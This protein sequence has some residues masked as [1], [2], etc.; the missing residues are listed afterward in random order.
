MYYIV[1]DKGQRR[2]LTLLFH[3]LESQP[4]TPEGRFIILQEIT[5]KL[6]STDQLNLLNLFL[7]TYVEEHKE[8]PYNGYYLLIVAKNYLS[9][10][11]EPFAVQYFERILRNHVDL[12]VDGTSIH[13]VCLQNLIRL[14]E[15]PELKVTYYKSL[16]S[17]FGD[18]TDRGPAY[19]F[20]AKTY[21]EL[22]EW[23][24]AIQAYRNFLG[25]PETSVQGV[26][27]AHEQVRSIIEFYDYPNKNWT[28]ESLEDLVSTIKYAMWTRNARLLSR[29]R[30]K[31]NFF[32]SSWEEEGSDANQSF[33]DDLGS[34]L[35]Q[36]I[37]YNAELDRDSNYREAYLRTWGWSYRIKTWYLYFR[38]VDFPADPEIHGQWEWGGI[39]FGEKPFAGT[40]TEPDT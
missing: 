7:T 33:L 25:Y 31:V 11:A 8:D 5:K 32:A 26:P 6:H 14:V 17:R 12:E 1:G 29:Y 37:H 4:Q 23:D 36:R 13:Y 19:Y 20:L 2:E 24:L 10:G 35:T 18:K 9:Q 28:M 3:D 40:V 15:D 27:H 16:L 30:A 39:Y 21:E 34:F 38:R 22:G